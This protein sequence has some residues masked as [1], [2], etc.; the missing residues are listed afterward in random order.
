MLFYGSTA[1]ACIPKSEL[2]THLTSR[3]WH[4]IATYILWLPCK[5]LQWCK[6][7]PCS[8]LCSLHTSQ[9]EANIMDSATWSNSLEQSRESEYKLILDSFFL[10][11]FMWY[12]SFQA[13]QKLCP[14]NIFCFACQKHIAEHSQ[15]IKIRKK[16]MHIKVFLLAAENRIANKC[17]MCD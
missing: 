13:L 15:N 2:Q 16:S 3:G 7:Q 10:D 11:Y 1:T 12:R 14:P 5:N 4:Y 17:T 8:W 6:S 9:H